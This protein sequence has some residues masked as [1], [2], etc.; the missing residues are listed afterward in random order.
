[1]MPSQ[2]LVSP[3][4]R[5][6]ELVDSHQKFLDLYSSITETCKRLVPLEDKVLSSQ[7]RVREGQIS[8][9]EAKVLIGD[10]EEV[11]KLYDQL[12]KISVDIAALRKQIRPSEIKSEEDAI[13]KTSAHIFKLLC[14]DP[15]AEKG[16]ALADQIIEDHHKK[17]ETVEGILRELTSKHAIE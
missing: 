3:E 6:P 11:L 16:L 1:M 10:S 14:E 2:T 8:R 9:L 13:A 12:E 15:A 17:I 5:Q 4:K 7:N